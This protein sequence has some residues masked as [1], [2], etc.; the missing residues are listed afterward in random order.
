M[1]NRYRQ[2]LP[3]VIVAVMVPQIQAIAAP[4]VEEVSPLANPMADPL[5]PKSVAEGKRDLTPLE[6]GRI[7][8]KIQDLSISGLVHWQAEESELAFADWFRQ[9]RLGQVLPDRQS[10]IEDL[11]E[12]GAIAWENNRVEDARTIVE[13]LNEIQEVD[14]PEDESLLIPLAE[15]YQ[16]LRDADPAIALYRTHLEKL[17]DPYK[18]DILRLIAL[19]AADW[20]DYEEALTAYNEIEALDALTIGDRQHFA[21]L[22]ETVNLPADALRIQKQLPLLYLQELDYQ[23]MSSVYVKI[24]KNAHRIASFD[25]AIEANENAFA[26]A[27]ELKYLDIAETALDQLGQVYL[28]QD[29]IQFAM[30]VYE[31]LLIVQNESY[32]RYG[33]MDTYARLGEIYE[34][35]NLYPS[36]LVSWQQGLA[37]A[38][39]LNHNI[40][41]FTTALETFP[42]HESVTE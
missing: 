9:L 30:Q 21:K 42:P 6:T 24:A 13:R 28:A 17:E 7:R 25:E 33:M 4:E 8:R 26:L 20:F 1:I 18:A 38:K 5:V 11:G 32:N 41:F 23:N 29:N 3:A 16:L 22:Y 10:E 31:Q 15:A 36:A 2:L 35:A 14:F 12:I 39:E 37:I 40:D 27:W 34:Q 19:L